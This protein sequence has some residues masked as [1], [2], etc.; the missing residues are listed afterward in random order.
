M[1]SVVPVS[2]EMMSDIKTPME[3][4]RILSERCQAFVHLGICFGK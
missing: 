4:L 2:L 3:V 1:Y